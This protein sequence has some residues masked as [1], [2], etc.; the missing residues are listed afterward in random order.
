MVAGNSVQLCLIFLLAATTS[1]PHA[2]ADSTSSSNSNS[3]RIN[4]TSSGVQRDA[5]E[6]GSSGLLL[7]KDLQTYLAELFPAERVH[8]P[9]IWPSTQHETED[10]PAT[11]DH[12]SQPT[13]GQHVVF[14]GTGSWGYTLATELNGGAALA[15]AEMPNKLMESRSCI[16][17]APAL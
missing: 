5:P 9:L 10:V 17:R 14:P 3:N 7:L 12:E 1:C 15:G 4:A 13:S 11:A 6:G 8:H 2:Q 16:N